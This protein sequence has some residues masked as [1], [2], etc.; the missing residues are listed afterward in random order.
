MTLIFL[1]ILFVAGLLAWL[2]DL[3]NVDTGTAVAGTIVAGIGAGLFLGAW[4]L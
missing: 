4:T 1:T 2:L 3:G